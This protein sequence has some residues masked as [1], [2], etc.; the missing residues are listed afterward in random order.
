MSW[1][2][3]ELITQAYA[4]IGL[5]SYTFDLSADQQEHALKRMNT[6]MAS[7]NI[8]G[9]R[10][11]YPIPTTATGD[12]LDDDSGLPDYALEPVYTNLAVRLAAGLGKQV[13]QETALTAKD[14]FN[15]LMSLAAMPIE[16]DLPTTMPRGAG[17]KP[18]RNQDSQYISPPEQRILTG[19]D[20]EIEFT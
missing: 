6:M 13:P 10:L 15:T 4:E 16:K 14:S 17:N 9:I 7:W 12:D 19:E 3:R 11:G 1:T 2:K 18:W 20:G 8:K 5:A